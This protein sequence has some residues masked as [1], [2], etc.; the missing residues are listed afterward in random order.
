M[1]QCRPGL[2]V[3]GHQNPLGAESGRG[4]VVIGLGQH[5]ADGCAQHFHLL[6]RYAYE[7]QYLRFLGE[8]ARLDY[9]AKS[10]WLERQFVTSGAISSARL[11]RL[12]ELA[13]RWCDGY[14]IAPGPFR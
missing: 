5:R 12:F 3:A 4:Q 13:A 2:L 10:T 11:A 7:A 8:V 9:R 1:A 14:A 6:A